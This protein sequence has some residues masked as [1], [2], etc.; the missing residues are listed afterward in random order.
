M[1]IVSV[2]QVICSALL[3]DILLQ[4]ESMLELTA[5]CIARLHSVPVPDT[6][7]S[8]Q[9]Q[10]WSKI[11]QFRKSVSGIYKDQK[12]TERYMYMNR[13]CIFS[14]GSHT[15][16]VH[17][18]THMRISKN[19]NSLGCKQPLRPTFFNGH[20]MCTMCQYQAS[21]HTHTCNYEEFNPISY[22]VALF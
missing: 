18:Y 6:M 10:L 8:S 13:S 5:A 1:Y 22:R 4:N 17:V 11:A 3:D 12:K 20:P 19:H 2:L 7:R 16:F 9:T 14:L 21:S 15:V